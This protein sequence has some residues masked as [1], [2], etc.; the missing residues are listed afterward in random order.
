MIMNR[1][2]RRRQQKEQSKD[3]VRYN[4]SKA[5]IKKIKDEA[6][7]E[8]I[9]KAFILMLGLPVMVL[10]DKFGFGA[11]RLERLTDEVLELY[12]SYNKGFLTLDDIMN[13]LKEETGL[14]LIQRE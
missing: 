11:K 14:E 8:A 9:D 3:Q 12:D 6:M 7:T 4:L 1:S 13:T 10:H 2:E 5:D